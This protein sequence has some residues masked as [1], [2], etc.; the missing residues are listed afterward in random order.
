VNEI[1]AT[2]RDVASGWTADFAPAA[3]A[4]SGVAVSG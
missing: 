3:G 4:D 2:A 1:D